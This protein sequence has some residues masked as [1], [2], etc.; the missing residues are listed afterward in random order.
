MGLLA[1]WTTFKNSA[2]AK[3]VLAALAGAAALLLVIGTAFK[4]GADAEKGKVATEAAKSTERKANSD[5]QV[6]RSSAAQRRDDLMRWTR[7]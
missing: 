7:D 5:A 6:D 4:K 3:A 1:L 2:F